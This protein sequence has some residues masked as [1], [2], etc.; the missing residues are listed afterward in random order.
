MF[1][2][3][4]LNGMSLNFSKGLNIYGDTAF[5]NLKNHYISALDIKLKVFYLSLSK[6]SQ[7]RK[8]LQPSHKAFIMSTCQKVKRCT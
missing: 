2:D 7:A 5:I 4:N 6:T 8:K 3:S 1:D